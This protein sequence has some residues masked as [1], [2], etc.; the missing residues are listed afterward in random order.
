MQS[1]G[2]LKIGWWKLSATVTMNNDLQSK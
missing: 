1:K 2:L